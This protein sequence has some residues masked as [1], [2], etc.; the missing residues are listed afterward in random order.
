MAEQPENLEVIT[1]SSPLLSG[2][3]VERDYTSGIES[4]I[5][6]SQKE[7]D[8]EVE[9]YEVKEDI[10][11]GFQ[12]DK[13]QPE[14]STEPKPGKEVEPGAEPKPGEEAK[15]L[16]DETIEI[17]TEPG[18]KLPAESAKEFA[19]WM[20][21]MVGIYV[22]QLS[23]EFVRIDMN[24]IKFHIS[25]GNLQPHMEGVFDGVNERVKEALKFSPEEIKMFKAS[26]K[27][28]L[29][30]KNFEFANPQNAFLG[31]CAMLGF[32][33]YLVLRHLDKELK[34]LVLDAVK[35]SNPGMINNYKD[36]IRA[37]DNIKSEEDKNKPT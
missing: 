33:Q 35:V 28:W 27:A 34:K 25:E 11:K 36:G 24:N 10:T 12:F 6:Q 17:E 21:D 13:K 32:K 26:A 37:Q 4:Q 20:G 31:T 23:Y 30:Y 8:K 5:G 29:E 18:F 9:D 2:Q 3:V 16:I 7:P 22:P 15:K 1:Q 14:P 19:N